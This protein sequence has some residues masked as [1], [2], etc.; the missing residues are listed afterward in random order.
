MKKIVSDLNFEFAFG[1][2]SGVIDITKNFLELPRF[3][4]NEKYGEI[5]R[6]KSILKTLPFPYK[7]IQHE[8]VNL[9][10][11]IFNPDYERRV[12]PDKLYVP[13]ICYCQAIAERQRKDPKRYQHYEH[14]HESDF[15]AS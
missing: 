3:P 5:Q 6:F 9:P 15:I 13:K 1:Q 7:E 4:I 2:H 10:E 8:P 12:L 11:R 14:R